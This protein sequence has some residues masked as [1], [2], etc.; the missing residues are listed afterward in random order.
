MSQGQAE[1]DQVAAAQAGDQKAW[2]ELYER[3]RYFVKMYVMSKLDRSL[4]RNAE[5][6][7]TDVFI[8]VLGKQRE[9]SWT[10]RPFRAYLTVVARNMVID[11]NKSWWIQQ[12]KLTD[13]MSTMD[14]I[15]P[16]RSLEET[17]LRAI[18]GKI[19]GAIDNLSD[20]QKKAIVMRFWLGMSSEQIGAALGTNRRAVNA[21]LFRA[22]RKME[23]DPR[24]KSAYAINLGE[25]E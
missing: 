19:Q 12:V 13:D 24:A 8:R 22:Y 17:A 11:L 7:V 25:D 23:E 15:A 1:W 5:D 9:L 20:M 3:Y 10:G 16:D 14:R 18:S 6:L 21:T 2:A 4:R